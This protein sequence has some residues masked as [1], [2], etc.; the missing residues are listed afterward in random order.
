MFGVPVKCCCWNAVVRAPIRRHAVLCLRLHVRRS[1]GPGWPHRYTQEGPAFRRALSGF[2]AS[3]APNQPSFRRTAGRGP[4]QCGWHGATLWRFYEHPGPV[5]AT[6]GRDPLNRPFPAKPAATITRRAREMR[7]P[8]PR[9]TAGQA[10]PR[11]RGEPGR[12]G[13]GSSEAWQ[14]AFPCQPAVDVKPRAIKPPQPAYWKTNPGREVRRHARQTNYLRCVWPASTSQGF[15]H[16]K[17]IR[18]HV[19]AN[20][21]AAVQEWRLL[22]EDRVGAPAHRRPRCRQQQN[23]TGLKFRTVF[24]HSYASN[25][26]E[27]TSFVPLPM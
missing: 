19:G 10:S 9:I 24:Q 2:L 21:S 23:Q 11:C 13:P 3:V 15:V 18:I 8:G 1:A 27:R 16:Q 6:G 25:F 14:G 5:Q 4:E 22:R 26:G 17:H 20:S 7:L 12:L